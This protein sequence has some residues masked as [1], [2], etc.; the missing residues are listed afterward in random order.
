M[1]TKRNRGGKNSRTLW[2]VAVLDRV[3]REG[4]RCLLSKDMKE[5]RESATG[6]LRLE[7]SRH[8]NQGKGPGIS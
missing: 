6:Y 3:D 2:Q 4:F 8:R 7:H 1:G 5:V